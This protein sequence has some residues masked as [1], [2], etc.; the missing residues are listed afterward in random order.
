[1]SSI[2]KWVSG[3]LVALLEMLISQRT[4]AAAAGW[5]LINVLGIPVD[6]AT[7]FAGAIATILG[8]V[9]SFAHRP[10]GAPTAPEV[11]MAKLKAKAPA[12]D[13]DKPFV[14]TASGKLQNPDAE[15]PGSRVL[16]K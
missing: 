7:K 8:L 13:N 15:V 3:K 9:I 14:D 4:I 5:I 16:A 1:M 10:P 6:A 12:N 2:E 11:E